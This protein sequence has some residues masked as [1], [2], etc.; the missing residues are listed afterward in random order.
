MRRKYYSK[1]NIKTRYENKNKSILKIISGKTRKMISGFSACVLSFSLVCTGNVSMVSASSYVAGASTDNSIVMERKSVKKNNLSGSNTEFTMT[2]GG[3]LDANW[4]TSIEAN[5]T[6]PGD[7][8]FDYTAIDA[9]GN[10]GVAMINI[11]EYT[12]AENFFAM[13][14]IKFDG[15]TVTKTD[16]TIEEYPIG[17]TSK[18]VC[19][20]DGDPEKGIRINLANPWNM[21]C[22][23]KLTADDDTNDADKDGS[24]YDFENY[25]DEDGAE[26]FNNLWPEF[27]K[28]GAYPYAEGD[29]V[30][31]KFTVEQ[32]ANK[33]G[34]IPN[35]IESVAC[36]LDDSYPDGKSEWRD[37]KNEVEVPVSEADEVTATPKA[38]EVVTSS[39]VITKPGNSSSQGSDNSTGSAATSVKST[40]STET[41]N[42]I[43]EVTLKVKKKFVVS[44]E[45]IFKRKA[46]YSDD[47][48]KTTAKVGKIYPKLSWDVYMIGNMNY[49]G[50]YSVLRSNTKDGIY[51]LIDSTFSTSFIDETAEKD[52]TYYYK[53][54]LGKVYESDSVYFKLDKKLMK[55]SVKIKKIKPNKSE[56]ILVLKVKKS[57]GSYIDVQIK[58]GDKWQINKKQSGS[59]S[60]KRLIM[61]YSNVNNVKMRYRFN[62][63]SGETMTFGSWSKPVTL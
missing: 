11:P 58:S 46:T 57:E 19:Y 22:E 37:F 41:K 29:K 7:Y 62:S 56:N 31:I 59:F 61:S 28:D 27:F 17:D 13:W 10:S 5:I 9:G 44:R 32:Y 23:Y 18:G 4:G 20:V 53:I 60:A 30:S 38:M 3:D 52:K 26:V 25:L 24:Y 51:S 47:L 54:S 39:P 45:S 63:K 35:L 42:E 50:S 33:S 2:L 34:K 49:T 55:P 15:V 36:K 40:G 8:S 14:N 43:K 21:L 48:F 6:G 1:D 12:S 16:G